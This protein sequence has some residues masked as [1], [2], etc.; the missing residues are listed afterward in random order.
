MTGRS[1]PTVAERASVPRG[2]VLFARYAYPPN[3]LG[4]CGP[5]DG[6]ELLDLA[7]GTG[8]GDMSTRARQFDGAWPYLEIIATATGIDDPLDRRVVEAYWVGNELLDDVEHEYFARQTRRCFAT[9]TGADWS[10]LDPDLP[11]SPAPHHSFHVFAI[12]PWMGMLRKGR[13]G[14]A[15]MVLDRCRIRWGQVA[16]LRGEHVEVHTQTL[17]WDGVVLGLG[18]AQ[19]E[20]VRWAESG[21]SLSAPLAPGDWV[22]LH[23]DWVCDKLTA[24]QLD[25]LRR[26][27]TRQLAATNRRG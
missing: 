12:Y 23:W 17:T 20:T 9:Q 18:D 15:L 5:G 19:R 2:D 4:Y 26:F 22:S 8:A 27:T 14:P 24:A 16:A 6:R 7:A 13:Q 11:T 10:C 21:R 1:E 3:E 25:S